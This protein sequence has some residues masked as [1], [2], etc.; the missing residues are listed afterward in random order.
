MLVNKYNLG[1]A[2]DAD[3]I[4]SKDSNIPRAFK[5]NI[6]VNLF[7]NSINLLDFGGRMEG[8]EYLITQLMGPMKE[9]ERK[10][11]PVRIE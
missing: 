4:W 9:L 1:Y 2:A 7:G 3:L 10:D 11:Q 6:T 8:I 5:T